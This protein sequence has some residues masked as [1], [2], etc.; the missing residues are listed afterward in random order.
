MGWCRL[1]RINCL[2]EEEKHE[3][4]TNRDEEREELTEIYQAKGFTEPLLTKIIDVLMADDNKLLQVMLEEEL[5]V[6][7]DTYVHPLK[8]ACG[9]GVGVIITGISIPLAILISPLYGLYVSTFLI[10]ALCSLLIAKVERINVLENTV[11]G[12]SITFL[13]IFSTYFLTKFFIYEILT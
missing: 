11:K 12:L 6:P 4:E 7:M 8:Q 1:E 5:G 9:A 13:T 10:T 2:I 3:I